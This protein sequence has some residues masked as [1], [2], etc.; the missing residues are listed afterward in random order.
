MVADRLIRGP[1]VGRSLRSPL[2]GASVHQP[3]IGRPRLSLDFIAGTDPPKTLATSSIGRDSRSYS[4]IAFRG[5]GGMRETSC[6]TSFCTSRR[7]R[8]SSGSATAPPVRGGDSV[9]D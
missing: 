2:S 6:R 1:G 3:G 5:S 7:P 4:R 9:R 8:F